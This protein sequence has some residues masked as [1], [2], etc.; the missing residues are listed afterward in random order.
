MAGRLSGSA[1][2]DKQEAASVDC[3][4]LMDSR[5]LVNLTIEGGISRL[6]RY[7]NQ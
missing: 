7:L 1:V 4:L 3:Y 5:K 2:L 6:D